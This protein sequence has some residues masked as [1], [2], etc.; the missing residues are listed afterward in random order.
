M[1]LGLLLRRLTD[2]GSRLRRRR[3]W[4]GSDDRVLGSQGG[5]VTGRCA[6]RVQLAG[7]HV[8]TVEALER[9]LDCRW[10]AGAHAVLVRLLLL[11]PL[12]CLCWRGTLH[13]MTGA[14]S[15]AL[16]L[17]IISWQQHTSGQLSAAL[18]VLPAAQSRINRRVQM[19]LCVR[20]QTYILRRFN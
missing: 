13:D 3:L 20:L 16:V 9:V 15:G 14:L 12:H 6:W 17:S 11:L 5:I 7:V 18:A 19:H 2:N 1:A 8:D 10:V 4:G